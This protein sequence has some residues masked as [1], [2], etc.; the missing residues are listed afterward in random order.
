MAKQRGLVMD[1]NSIKIRLF[2]LAL[3]GLFSLPRAWAQPSICRVA[4]SLPAYIFQSTVK[5]LENLNELSKPLSE[6]WG[7]AGYDGR[8]STALIAKFKSLASLGSTDVYRGMWVTPEE[9]I[10]ISKEGLR[11]ADG[12]Y[13]NKI[14]FSAD[15]GE[16]IRYGAQGAE[17]KKGILILIAAKSKVGNIYPRDADD[18]GKQMVSVA[19]D[20]VPAEA[21]TSM[22]VF[23]PDTS[24]SEL[25]PFRAVNLNAIRSI[26][27]P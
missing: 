5:T 21:I 26:P 18:K 9:L 20:H 14:H 6:V 24:R 16:A 27:S 1:Q 19:D 7:R 13:G 12:N 8:H 2:L 15:P 11:A 10:K 3:L 17:D 4:L 25:Q 23:D 22:W